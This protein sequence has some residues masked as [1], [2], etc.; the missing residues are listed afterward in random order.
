MGPVGSQRQEVAKS[1]AESFR[2]S[3]IS[4]GDLL[5]REEAKKSEDGKRIQECFNSFRLGKIRPI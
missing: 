4:M 5:R 1:V 2:W 3:Y